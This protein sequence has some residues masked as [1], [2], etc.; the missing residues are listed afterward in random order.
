MADRPG[1]ETP[2]RRPIPD[3][4]AL[5]DES[6]MTKTIVRAAADSAAAAG[7]GVEFG[8]SRRVGST[9]VCGSRP[10]EWLVLGDPAPALDGL[11]RS[12]HVTVMDLTHGRA[13]LRLTTEHA[14]SVLE[15]VCSLDFSDSMTPDGAVTT[16]SVAKVICDLIRDEVGGTP[17]YLIACD[18]SLG[19]WLVGALLDACDE[20]ESD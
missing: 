11:D 18:R 13:L 20:F 12:G 3:G 2:I 16:A 10:D 6:A 19:D 15:K 1:F 7:L 5:T 4:S 17:S 8:A 9:L 14:P